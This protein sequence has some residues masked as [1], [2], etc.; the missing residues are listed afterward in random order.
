MAV[1]LI[2]AAIQGRHVRPDRGTDM[3]TLGN[4]ILMAQVC[5]AVFIVFMAIR[6]SPAHARTFY[7]ASFLRMPAIVASRVGS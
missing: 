1:K 2:T 6:P 7:A 4:L 3:R 5:V